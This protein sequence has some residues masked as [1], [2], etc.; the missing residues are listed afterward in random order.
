M[1]LVFM[2]LGVCFAAIGLSD[3]ETETLSAPKYGQPVLWYQTF[4]VGCVFVVAGIS[5]LWGCRSRS[6]PE[7]STGD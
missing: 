6:G 5:V 2:C 4:G 3:K 7:E 1:A